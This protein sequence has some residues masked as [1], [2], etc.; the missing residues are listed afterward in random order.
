[1]TMHKQRLLFIAKTAFRD[2]RKNIGKLML[3]MS[4]IIAGV[5]ALVAINSFNH[6]LS[7]DI[8]N[9]AATLLGA[10]L[11]VTSNREI[12]PSILSLLD[13]L[14]GEKSQEME[15]FSMVYVRKTNQTH[16]MRLKGLKGA[17]PYYGKLKTYPESAAKSYQNNNSLLVD[18]SFL[19]QYKLSIGDS[20][21]IGDKQFR[22]EGHL[23]TTF[24]SAAITS[25]FAPTIYM[26]LQSLKSTSLIQ[27][28]S[29]I[30]YANY[31]KVPANFNINAWQ[32]KSRTRF[33]SEGL[34][35]ET[36]EDR[37]G[38]LNEA[39]GNLN[40]FLNLVAMVSLLLGSIGVASSVFI[41]VK[42]KVPSIAVMRCLGLKTKEAFLIYFSQITVLGFFAVM[43]GAALGSMIQTLLPALLRDFLP[44]QITLGISWK[45]FFDGILI[46][47]TIT[48]L[49]ALVP[50][51]DIRKISPLLTLRTSIDAT[52]Q[53]KDK[54]TWLLYFVIGLSIFL[55]M[56]RITSSWMDAL[57]FSAGL[58]L[59][60]GVLYTVALSFLY[61]LRK[62]VPSGLSFEIRQGISNLYRPSNQT[63]TLI[64]SI[65]LGTAVLTTLYVIQGLLLSNVSSMDAG[66]QPNTILYGIE[67]AQV[68]AL[69]DTTLKYHLPIMQSVPIVTMKLESWKG[70]DKKEW[71]ADTIN[72]RDKRWA[73]NREARVTYRDTISR[74]ESL[75]RGKMYHPVKNEGD[76]VF[77][78]LADSYAEALD[79][80]L[81]DEMVFNVQGTII[82]TYVGSIRKIDFNN[83]S[84]RFFIIFPTGIIENAPQFHIIV[85]K[86]PDAATTAFYRTAV[87][88]AFPNVS[89]VDLGSILTAVNEILNKVSYVIK[90]M[91]FFSLI[92][93]L[94]VLL[95]SLMLSKFQR[96]GESVLLRTLG[97]KK[98]SIYL[99]NFIEYLILGLLASLSG[100]IISLLAS[101]FIAKYQFRLDFIMNAWPIISIV[102][103]ITL[104]TVLVGLFNSKEVVSKPPLEVLRK[105]A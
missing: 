70:K 92:T 25:A 52:I 64:L 90:F 56:M 13:S 99:I 31:Y 100:V 5:A 54:W 21:K 50:L 45:A 79:V 87:V 35:A 85:T 57:L 49:F 98:K 80:D 62:G 28:G 11:A 97:A 19:L 84:T 1:M 101:F 37:K 63:K 88:K 23:L 16:F 43:T 9:Q 15:I 34:R 66:N 33:R 94:I 44:M 61:L 8:N 10:D 53:Q 26:P 86:I 91:A 14:P 71:L 4:S 72:S 82:K 77:V 68:K 18:E 6:N 65:G 40:Y 22:I 46:G 69:S 73:M 60:F 32:E 93:G 30:N 42:T 55:F 89:V 81:G 105:E 24:G 74:Q 76:T 103:F 20:I 95:S 2:S 17:F 47:S 12:E 96:I 104:V 38:N 27:S 83:M 102:F 78:S 75:L 48:A 36:I 41:Y 51:L 7:Q 59:A 29:L 58:G 67:T 39:F 3:F